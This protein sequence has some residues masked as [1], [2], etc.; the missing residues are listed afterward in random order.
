MVREEIKPHPILAKLYKASQPETLT[1]P[2]YEV[3]MKCPPVP[4][5]SVDNGG[6]VFTPTDVVRLPSQSSQRKKMFNVDPVQ[7]YPNFD[8]LNQ[9]ASVPWKVNT[10]LLDVILQASVLF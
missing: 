4:W 8:S 5:T 6:Y 2:A 9:L 3:P 1:F 7:L 10:K